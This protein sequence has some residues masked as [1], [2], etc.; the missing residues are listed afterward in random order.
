[1]PELWCVLPACEPERNIDIFYQVS[2][3]SSHLPTAEAPTDDT[4]Q[5]VGSVNLTG[6]RSSTVPLAGVHPSLGVA[7]T[8]HL[9]YDGLAAVHVLGLALPLVHQGHLGGHQTLS[10]DGG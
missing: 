9:R 2:P 4:D 10:V 5:L 6:E 3:L 1:M 7:S 8:H